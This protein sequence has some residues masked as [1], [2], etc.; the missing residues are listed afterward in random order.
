[1]NIISHMVFIIPRVQFV[2]D[3]NSDIDSVF[4]ESSENCA[5]D[6]I[7]VKCIFNQTLVFQLET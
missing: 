1:M 4:K 2:N 5:S 3:I 6:W 7:L